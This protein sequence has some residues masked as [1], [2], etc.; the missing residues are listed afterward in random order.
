MSSDFD[1]DITPSVTTYELYQIASY[2][3]WFSLGEFID[4]AITSAIKNRSKLKEIYGDDY[5]LR[6]NID[7]V[8][9]SSKIII[10]DNAAGINSGEMERALRAGEPPVDKTLLSVHGVGMKMSAFWLGRNLNIKTWS[11][12]EDEGYEVEL[13]LDSIKR[14]KSTKS[15]VHIIPSRKEKGTVVTISKIS[16]DKWPPVGRGQGKLRSLLSSMYRLYLN[17]KEFPV[18][19]IFAG[20]PL[21][22]SEVAYLNAPY[23]DSTQGPK[24]GEEEVRWVR[25]FEYVTKEGKRKIV[26]HIGLL[27]TMSRNMS[28]LFL[29]YRGKGM[30]GIGASDGNNS[31]LKDTREYYRPPRIFGQEG[32]YRHQR[33]TGEFDISALGKTAS[34][35][36]IKWNEDEEE[37]F[38]IALE[39]FLKTSDFNMW[40]MAENFQ[41]RKAKKLLEV[42]GLK[43]LED[44]TILEVDEISNR[45]LESIRPEVIS[46]GAEDQDYQNGGSL[47]K[48]PIDEFLISETSWIIRDSSNHAHKVTPEFIEDA[49]LELFELVHIDELNHE[50]RIN[51][52]HPF[53]R[54]F[55]WGNRDVRQSMISMIYLMA[56]PEML[57]PHRCSKSSFKAKIFEILSSTLKIE[58]SS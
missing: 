41:V 49:R 44:F 15:T 8:H 37:E 38:L 45:F 2:T 30:S 9:D 42:N 46:H 40:A 25:E 35:D 29:H 28:G 14:T 22:F 47:N 6:V 57:L 18:E 20:K 23:W 39:K 24:E 32:S 54:R 51:I 43:T 19:I 55:Q 34:T 31:E 58:A 4:N 50:L 48:V 16:E 56:I 10:T 21:T 5:R 33:F 13:D 11:V 36:S 52:G 53:V 17:D 3:H 1:I 27:E 26:G 12:D 7:L